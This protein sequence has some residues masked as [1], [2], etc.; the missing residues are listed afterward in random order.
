MLL[1]DANKHII[2]YL[3][4]S[5]ILV[6]LPGSADRFRFRSQE[7]VSGAYMSL[8]RLLSHLQILAVRSRAPRPRPDRADRVC[9]RYG[10]RLD[11]REGNQP[12]RPTSLSALSLP[13][14]RPLAGAP[15]PT[16]GRAGSGRPTLVP[17][18][19]V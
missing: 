2:S 18:L 17:L 1:K 19:S 5:R 11:N 9:E 12:V 4:C 3:I 6:E 15:H 10:A 14:L 7:G 8:P 16:S 13:E